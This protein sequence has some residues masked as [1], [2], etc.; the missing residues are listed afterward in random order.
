MSWNQRSTTD[1][2]QGPAMSNNSHDFIPDLTGKVAI[3]TGGHT[4]LGFGT[5]IELAKYGARVYIASRSATKF[6]DAKRIILSEF[7]KADV[8]FL[9]LD[10]TNLDSV[11]AAAEKFTE[12]ESSL[13]LLLNNAGVMC[14]PYE[15]T[16][17]GFEMQI[18][19]NYIGHFLFTK[20]LI[21]VLQKTADVGGKGSVRI[22]NV[23]SDGHAKLAPKEGIIFT[24]MNLENGFSVWARYGH[25]KLANVLHAKELAK[26]YP[27]ILAIS[28][29]PGTVK[30]NLSAGPISSTPLYRLIKPLV[31]LGAPGPRKGAANIIFACVSP[32][33]RLENDNGAYLL[34]VGKLSACSK[35][36]SDPKM[37]E[38]LWE[39][40]MEALKSRGYE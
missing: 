38:N 31:E 37:A 2:R 18:G 29:H 34:P 10:L 20:L 4:G 36:G 22:V 35:A 11:Q 7:P 30:T 1:V 26:R 28:L 32:K 15:E 6:N 17:D 23:S 9:T 16:V 24:D 39:W 19:V 27:N 14:V 21:P 3:V 12:Q 40:T 8:R 33:L 5:S 25:S 13:H